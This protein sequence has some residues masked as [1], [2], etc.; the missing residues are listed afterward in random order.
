MMQEERCPKD[1]KN[2][3]ASC[4]ERRKD[5][6]MIRLSCGPQPDT[7]K[8]SNGDLRN[9]FQYASKSNRYYTFALISLNTNKW[10][11]SFSLESISPFCNIDYLM[12]TGSSERK[13]NLSWVSQKKGITIIFWMLPLI[14]IFQNIH[15]W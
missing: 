9:D 11:L 7:Y 3:W 4:Q 14:I 12:Q 5:R 8:S 1:G 6:Q 15:Q 10:F 13:L 2:G